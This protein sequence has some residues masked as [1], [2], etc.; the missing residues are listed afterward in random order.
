[1]IRFFSILILSIFITSCTTNSV[2][3]NNATTG[4]KLTFEPNDNGE[5]DIIVFDPQYDIFLKSIARPK[6]YNTYEFYKSKNR[7]YT[8]IWNQRHM[9]PSVYDQN[10]YAVSIDLDSNVDYGLDFEYKLFNFFQF[11]EWKYKVRLM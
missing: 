10:L 7:M 9:M 3:N 11:I 5:Y 8:S 6:T 1:M 4:N 2:S